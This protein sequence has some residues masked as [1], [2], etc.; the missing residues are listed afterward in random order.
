MWEV[1]CLFWVTAFF[2]GSLL[3]GFSEVIRILDMIAMKGYVVIANAEELRTAPPIGTTGKRTVTQT[4]DVP[5]EYIDEPSN[6]TV[7]TAATAEIPEVS[8][9]SFTFQCPACG[10]LQR[11][12]REVCWKCGTRF[13]RLN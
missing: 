11:Y 2:S 12:D 13:Q 6:R 4:A 10:A 9:K 1:A 3:L 5:G 7:N 8:A